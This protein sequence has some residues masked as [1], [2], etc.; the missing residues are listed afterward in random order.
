MNARPKNTM[1]D[2]YNLFKKQNC[3]LLHHNNTVC[4]IQDIV[5][6]PRSIALHSATTLISRR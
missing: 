6:N 3:L 1:R 5:G 4:N 2:Q